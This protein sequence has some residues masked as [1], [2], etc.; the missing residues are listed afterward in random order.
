MAYRGGR[1]T[2][3]RRRGGPPTGGPPGRGPPMRGGRPGIPPT[4]GEYGG[5]QQLVGPPSDE[6]E[7]A[8]KVLQIQQKRFYVDVKENTR[9]RFL[10]M[11]EVDTSGRKSRVV[12]TMSL[13]KEFKEHLSTLCTLYA[14]LGSPTPDKL[15]EGG[16]IK[17]EV[18]T[19]G[20]RRYYI[21]LRENNRGRFLRVSQ[22][23]F[24]GPRFVIVIPGQGLIE[25]RDTISKLLD[26]YGVD[27]NGSEDLPEGKQFRVDN[28]TF[29]FDIG[30]NPRGVYMRISEVQNAYRSAITL[31]DRSWK[32]F[33]DIFVEVCDKMEKLQSEG[34]S[35]GALVN[36]PIGEGSNS[37][38]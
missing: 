11:T 33:R 1:E 28:K 13:A 10:K 9:G 25:F 7:L 8:S 36:E 23:I 30:Q 24:N 38:A 5:G 27:D 3:S 22:S 4:R 21:D 37:K 20:P 31:P 19:R 17:S 29:Y 34:G 6:K 14:S 2:F 16:Q 32:R 18:I 35:I 26:E 12:M 15:P